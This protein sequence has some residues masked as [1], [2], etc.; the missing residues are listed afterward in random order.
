[1]A[2]GLRRGIGTGCYIGS[3]SGAPHERATVKISPENAVTV[4][5]GTLSAGQGHETSFVQL[6]S[7]WLR[8]R[9]RSGDTGHR[10]YGLAHHGWRVPFRTIDAARGYNDPARKQRNR[11]QGQPNCRLPS[12]LPMP[13]T[14]AS[15]TAHFVALVQTAPLICSRSRRR[16]VSDS[17]V[18]RKTCGA[19]CRRPA[20]ST[21]VSHPSRTVA[22]SPRLRSTLTP[23]WLRLRAIPPSMMSVAP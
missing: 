3:A 9:S 11:C 4:T 18:C 23:V 21:A 19:P 17:V 8:R 13:L 10:R 16:R 22:T 14:S 12:G 2:K 6:V 7:E 15:P 5:I 1:M 20:M